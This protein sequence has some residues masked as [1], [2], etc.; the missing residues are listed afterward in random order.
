M[1]QTKRTKV[2]FPWY[3]KYTFI[4]AGIILTI[5][6]AV[7]AKAVL[8]PILFALFLS[9]LLAPFCN[10]I[11][12][13]KIPRILSTVIGI[14]LGV[15][16]LVA[17][18]FFIYT[19][20]LAFAD[21]VYLFRERFEEMTFWVEDFISERFGF[22]YTF[23]I[24]FLTTSFVEFFGDNIESFFSRVAGVA[25]VFTS[26]FLVPVFMFLLLNFR[27]FLTEFLFRVFGRQSEQG[28]QT[29]GRVINRI[30]KV[31]QSYIVGIIM[32]ILI[33]AVLNSTMLLI[34][35]VEHAI[36]FGVF[37]AIL[38]VVPFIGPLVGSILPIL[39][40]L[41]T[42]DSLFYPLIIM[43]GFYIIQLME[44]NFFTPVI[45]GS[46]VSMNAFIALLLLFIGAQVWGLVGMILVIPIG[47][48]LKV[49]F[50]EVDSLKPYGYVMGRVPHSNTKKGPLAE[51]IS[52]M[53][54]KFE[55]R[56]KEKKSEEDEEE[57]NS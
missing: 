11:E 30:K 51:K 9:M 4:L 12:R 44:S 7:A 45:V 20:L 38:N 32:V 52:S 28:L 56:K 53:T 16:V 50:D 23:D 27:E 34:I 8:Q 42:M 24:D 6:A 3:V 35:G 22:E 29:I 10:F 17:V 13:Y 41:I 54:E 1:N 19:Q 25:S 40:A 39:Y 46:Q 2:E 43:L 15:S 33:L 47:A 5:Y 14:L 37:A 36:F 21:D 26:I 31:V 57:K 18:G 55:E 48:I 49:I